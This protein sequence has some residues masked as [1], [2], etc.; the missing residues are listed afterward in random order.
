MLATTVEQADGLD[1]APD[2]LGGGEQLHP[3]PT[4]AI[5]GNAVDLIQVNHGNHATLVADVAH[6][7]RSVGKDQQALSLKS[8][9]DLHRQPVAVD[10]DC[11]A[12]VTDRRRGYDG[13]EAVVEQQAQQFRFDLLDAAAVV[14]VQ[15]FDFVAFLDPQIRLAAADRDT[16]VHRGQ[17]DCVRAEGPQPL[18][19]ALV[20]LARVGHQEMIH[21]GRVGEAADL[22]PLGGH[23]P[24][25]MPEAYG[26]LIEFFVSAMDEN[27][28]LP[29]GGDVSE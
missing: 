4:L 11:D 25:W 5:L 26:E 15:H 23:H 28:R 20:L 9:G 21:G 24:R 13:Q 1:A 12:L 7:S 3:G 17:A 2:R 14:A 27:E 6:E 8:R 10:V 19:D 16:A 29:A 22:A 18:Y